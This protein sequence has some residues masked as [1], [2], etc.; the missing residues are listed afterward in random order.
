MMVKAA[1]VSQNGGG[2]SDGGGENQAVTPERG[3]VPGGCRA[4]SKGRSVV[5]CSACLAWRRA[6]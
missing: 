3:E 1:S 5:R 6:C 4:Q 2:E